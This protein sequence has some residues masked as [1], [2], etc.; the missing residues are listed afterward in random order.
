MR[1][2]L[3]GPLHQRGTCELIDLT[4][5]VLINAE[6]SDPKPTNERGLNSYYSDSV[7]C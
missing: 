7:K 2:S 1:E 4:T 5:N 6:L 3:T